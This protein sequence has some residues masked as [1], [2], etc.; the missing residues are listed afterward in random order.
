MKTTKMLTILVLSLGLMVCTAELARA[1]PMGTAFTYQGRLM[2][3]NDTADGLY[4]FEFKLWMDP[5]EIVYPPQVG[6]TLTMNDLDVID[7]YFTVELD[8]NSPFAFNGY[9]RWLETAVRPGD[10][11]DPNA[12]VTLS[13]RQELTPT[14]YAIYAKTAGGVPGGISGSGTANYIAKFTGP[15]T[16]GDSAI[17]ESAGKVGIGTTTPGFRFHQKGGD[18][19]VDDSDISL[20]RDNK[21]RWRLVEGPSSG[22][23]IRQVYNDS[24][25]LQNSVRMEI[26]DSGNIGIGTTDPRTDLEIQGTTGLRVTT[27]QHPN[28][29]GDF[30]HAYSGGLIINANAGGG[31]WADMSLQTNGTTRMFIE[32]GGNVGIGTTGNPPERLYCQGKYFSTECKYGCECGGNWRGPRL[33]RRF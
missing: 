12:F 31:G 19:V 8:F 13:P 4:D 30:K 20:R 9:A 15:N 1:A 17:Y 14:P 21:H 27:G 26:S 33:C 25:T 5:C 28:V 6:D 18:H 16:L 10:S 11:N 23:S 7:G 32:S 29:Y 2:D 24:G 3:A 22:L